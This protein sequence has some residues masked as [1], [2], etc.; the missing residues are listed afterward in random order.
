MDNLNSQ[1]NQGRILLLAAAFVIIIA[2]MRAAEPIIVPVLLSIFIAVITT[3]PMFWLQR[4]GVP[5]ALAL[6]LVITGMFVIVIAM[7]ALVGT[8]LQGFTQDLPTYQARIR[9]QETT[10]T[11]WLA[12][13][14]IVI[15]QDQVLKFIDPSKAMTLVAALLNGLGSMLTNSFLIFLTV[16]FILMEAPSFPAKLRAVMNDPQASLG[17]FEMFLD[18]VKRYLAIKTS[19]SLLTGVIIGL[20]VFLVGV[21]YP[22]LWGLLAFLLNYIPN[23]GSIIAAVPTT[24]LA[25]VQLGAGA[26]AWVALGYLVVNNLV[27]NLIE[28]RFMGRGLG[29]STLVVFISLVFWGWVFGAVG[30]FLAVPLT[31]M[32]KIALDSF[33]STRWIAILLGPEIPPQEAA[34][35]TR[36]GTPGP[37]PDA[38]RG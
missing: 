38:P 17:R 27:G 35:Q 26:A 9:E 19:T 29:L 13:K 14:G 25:L 28:P 12:T 22:V 3:P 1:S 30:M 32:A 23:I 36:A 11:L 7:M 24:L 2:G 34:A 16:I 10:L 18:N 33:E 4:K 21:D 31:M 6:I 20:W 8:S 15:P 37:D 5:H